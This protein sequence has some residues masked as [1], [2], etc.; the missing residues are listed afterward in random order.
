MWDARSRGWAMSSTT[1][2]GRPEPAAPPRRWGKGPLLVPVTLLV[3]VA[4]VAV[5]HLWPVSPPYPASALHLRLRTLELVPGD[6]AQAR[7][8]ALAGPGRLQ[9][10]VGLPSLLVGQVSYDVPAGADLSTQWSF[11][12]LDGDGTPLPNVHGVTSTGDA[13]AGWDSSYGDIAHQ[14][15]AL[16]GLAPVADGSGGYTDPGSSLSVLAPTAGP[17]TFVAIP[18]ENA[19]GD[20]TAYS[21]WTTLQNHDSTLFWAVEVPR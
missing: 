5:H 20:A 8:D 14:V 17:L 6:Q 15:P 4:L 11:F 7:V 2:V 9:V 18:P 3:L 10:P 19:L 1:T 12:L 16:H 13:T 21:V